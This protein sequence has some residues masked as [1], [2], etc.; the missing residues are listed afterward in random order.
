MKAAVLKEVGQPI[1]LMEQPK[2]RPGAGEVLIKLKA[3][4]L[5]HRDVW[6]Q[7]GRYPRMKLPCILGSDGAGTVESTGPGVDQAWVGR[8]VI[9]NPGID[10]GRDPRVAGESFNILGMPKDGTFAE[11]TS[12]DSRYVYEKPLLLSMEEAAALPLAS[13]TAYRAL[14]VRGKLYDGEKVLVTGIGGGVAVLAAQMA[15]AERAQVAVTSGST[16]KLK[17]A[18]ELGA[19]FIALYKEDGWHKKL[20]EEAG[21]FDLIIDGAGGGDF[22]KLI[23]L[24][25]PA[26]RIVTYGGTAGKWEN[27]NPASVFFKQLDIKGTTMGTRSDF[28]T[29]LDFVHQHKIS[30]VIDKKYP[31]DDAD[32]A[33]QRMDAGEQF[34]KIILKMSD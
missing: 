2:P 34:G 8:D 18:K 30:P 15:I 31:L 1:E 22:H 3:A 21:T 16:K 29:M 23:D 17:K 10:W 19:S 12:I 11:Y 4:A 33:F 13:L 9:I 14:F 7:K 28:S 5:N 32:K 24:A 20:R 6:V 27:I 25:A 26:G